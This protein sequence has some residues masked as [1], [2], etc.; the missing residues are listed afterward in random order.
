MSSQSDR[1]AGLLIGLVVGDKN[2]GP[3]HMATLVAESLHKYQEFNKVN[4][5]TSY[6]NW[7]LN[8]EIGSDDTGVVGHK[9]FKEA[10]HSNFLEEKNK[11]KLIDDISK[12]VD[13]SMKGLTAG[14]NPSHRNTPL[15]MAKFITKEKLIEF[16]K[17]EC[18]M[19]HQ[20]ILAQETSMIANLICRENIEG[21]LN[22]QQILESLHQNYEFERETE[23]AL[24]STMLK[25]KP[26]LDKGGFSPK[27]L[28]TVLCFIDKYTK[29][30]DFSKLNS[31]QRQDIFKECMTDSFQF[32]GKPNYSP[33]LVG[34]ILGSIVGA[35]GIPS[36]IL[37]YFQ[38]IK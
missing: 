5:F 7:F 29:N 28:E 31:N 18:K 9:I 11:Q 36:E 24:K 20:N 22:F 21:K 6:L 25:F 27:T 10:I 2:L 17:E 37:G 14:I 4:I 16:S 32:A 34:S 23:E 26:R 35:S 30:I 3:M 15:S 12:K 33:V 19:T 1:A 8:K 38:K 13:V